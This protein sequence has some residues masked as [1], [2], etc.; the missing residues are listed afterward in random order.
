[1]SMLVTTS[2]TQ[3]VYRNAGV[4]YEY[5]NGLNPWILLPL[6][7]QRPPPCS[8]L[9]FLPMRA[10]TGCYESGADKK[11]SRAGIIRAAFGYPG[12]TA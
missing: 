6:L 5:I 7:G 1:M 10:Q 4:P 3:R 11:I 8:A 12:R 2:H 9:V